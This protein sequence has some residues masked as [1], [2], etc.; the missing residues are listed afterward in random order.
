[1]RTI[2]VHRRASNW[3]VTLHELIEAADQAERE[4]EK[5]ER[6]IEPEVMPEKKMRRDLDAH[7]V[8]VLI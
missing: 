1:M 3:T 6:N 8:S 7:Q 5:S 4:R 2:S